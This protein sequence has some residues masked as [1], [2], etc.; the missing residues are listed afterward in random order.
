MPDENLKAQ[1]EEGE[2]LE[3]VLIHLDEVWHRFSRQITADIK[4]CP[5]PVPLS[6]A[7]L[8]RL[9]DRRG[10][11]TMSDLATA[12]GIKLSGCTALVDRAIEAGWVERRRDLHDRRVVWVEVSLAGEHALNQLRQTRARILA[13]YLTRLQPEEIETLAS[14][15]NRVTLA[16]EQDVTT[17]G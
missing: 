9:L 11:L 2:K 6:Q 3:Q 17:L 4:D 14:L 13:R 8:L 10:A 15:L 7:Y 12:L 5:L 1:H 16:L